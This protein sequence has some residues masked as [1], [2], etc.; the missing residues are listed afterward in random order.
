METFTD[1]YSKEGEEARG[2]TDI[3]LKKIDDPQ[4][5]LEYYI[6][7]CISEML[8]RVGTPEMFGDLTTS[9]FFE[10][11]WL[12]NKYQKLSNFFKTGQLKAGAVF[13]KG[14]AADDDLALPYDGYNR[15]NYP[16]SIYPTTPETSTLSSIATEYGIP[17]DDLLEANTH[18]EEDFGVENLEPDTNIQEIWQQQGGLFAIKLPGPDLIILNNSNNLNSLPGTFISQTTNATFAKRDFL[19][20]VPL[21]Y[22]LASYAIYFD[23]IVNVN[24]KTINSK[25]YSYRRIAAANDAFINAVI[26]NQLGQSLKYFNPFPALVAGIEYYTFDQMRADKKY[27]DG[28]MDKLGA[29]ESAREVI[30]ANLDKAKDF[31]ERA[32]NSDHADQT[33]DSIR[34]RYNKQEEVLARYTTAGGITHFGALF[35]ANGIDKGPWWTPDFPAVYM[36]TDTDNPGY[37]FH[38][39]LTAQSDEQEFPWGDH[40]GQNQNFKTPFS[41][42][43][44]TLG[45]NSTVP[46]YWLGIEH[47]QE[48]YYLSAYGS[49]WIDALSIILPGINLLD[50]EAAPT[51]ALIANVRNA[52]VDNIRGGL[53]HDQITD[54]DRSMTWGTYFDLH[55]GLSRIPGDEVSTPFADLRRALYAFSVPYITEG[56]NI[57]TIDNFNLATRKDRNTFPDRVARRK[58]VLDRLNLGNIYNSDGVLTIGQLNGLSVTLGAF[59][60]ANDLGNWEDT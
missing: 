58:D 40:L 51:R 60:S 24:S 21:P 12:R 22:I 16:Q 34:W 23:R 43:N 4:K 47:I 59:L 32:E 15:D 6:R 44:S 52:L 46:G 30:A 41:K 36:A 28:M 7:Q 19:T 50:D 25:F 17:I 39:L 18:I 49:A 26:P 8:K 3:N 10:T 42:Q 57:D 13:G 37:W 38:S 2:L 1:V 31:L 11:P 53:N 56:R 45:P 14:D 55:P 33:L 29:V 5:Q 27:I 9:N 20:F 35:Q 48:G 54:T